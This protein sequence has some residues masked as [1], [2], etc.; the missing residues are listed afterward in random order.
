MFNFKKKIIIM[1]SL[2]LLLVSSIFI[3]NHYYLEN[4]YESDTNKENETNDTKTEKISEIP[5]SEKQEAVNK[6]VEEGMINISYSSSA[7]FD[8]KNSTSFKVLNKENNRYPIDF[9]LYDENDNLMFQSSE[10]ALGY[11]CTE[12]TLNENHEKGTF[13]WKIKIGY[14]NGNE[15]SN[16]QSFFP[17]N[18]TIN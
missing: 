10:I 13:E 3:Y 2:I 8:G 5:D 1:I 4:I 11:Q 12:I 17:I 6:A 16:V 9:E 15:K 18:V 7:V 14:S